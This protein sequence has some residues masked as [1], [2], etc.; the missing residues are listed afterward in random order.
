MKSILK[1]QQQTKEIGKAQLILTKQLEEYYNTGNSNHLKKIIED[2]KQNQEKINRL[3]NENVN[4]EIEVEELLNNKK[5]FD[6]V[7]KD[8]KQNQNQ[9]VS[10]LRQIIDQLKIEYQ[11]KMDNFL[12]Q[13]YD[14]NSEYKK[15]VESFKELQKKVIMLGKLVANKNQEEKEIMQMH[16]KFSGEVKNVENN[17]ILLRNEQLKIERQKSLECEEKLKKEDIDYQN[18]QKLLKKLQEQQKLKEKNMEKIPKNNILIEKAKNKEEKKQKEKLLIKKKEQLK[19]SMSRKEPKSQQIDQIKD[20]IKVQIYNDIYTEG[21][22]QIGEGIKMLKNLKQLNLDLEYN[23]ISVKGG[24]CI[25]EGIGELKKLTE[26]NLNLGYNKISV[27]GVQYICAGIKELKNLTQLNLYLG[28]NG[29]S[30]QGAQ[31]ISDG[32]KQLKN[33]TEL[34]LDLG[35][36]N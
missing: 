6:M 17:Q 1:I 14:K 15:K 12:K 7:L 33:L 24:E 26:L 9:E 16:L 18:Q 11:I 20:F 4:I 22:Q 5:E 8:L 29:I 34:N 28:Q 2:S 23:Q 19:S 21:A 36:L 27:Y 35:Q 13:L 30:V 10:E 3:Q 31:Y 25:G 32:I